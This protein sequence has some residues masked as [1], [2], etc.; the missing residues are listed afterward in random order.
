MECDGSTPPCRSAA[1]PLSPS[2]SGGRVT[3][4]G[5]RAYII[6]VSNNDETF[7]I[8]GEVFNTK[9]YCFNVN[10]GDKVIFLSGSPL[11]ACASAELLNLRTGKVCRVWCE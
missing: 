9:T 4:S 10:K 8:N 1:C 11:G 6:D 2:I 3:P 7:I 5:K